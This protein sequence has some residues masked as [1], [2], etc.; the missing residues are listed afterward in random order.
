[1]IDTP[2][3]STRGDMIRGLWEIPGDLNPAYLSESVRDQFPTLDSEHISDGRPSCASI[4]E[5][6]T[7]GDQIIHK[8]KP[9]GVESRCCAYSMAGWSEQRTCSEW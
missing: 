6:G 2:D 8:N 3:V 9:E 5:Y 7:C 4:F 1:M